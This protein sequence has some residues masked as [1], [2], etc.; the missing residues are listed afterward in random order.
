[1][2]GRKV[3]KVWAAIYFK[4]YKRNKKEGCDAGGHDDIQD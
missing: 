1:M 4:A 2:N 3:A